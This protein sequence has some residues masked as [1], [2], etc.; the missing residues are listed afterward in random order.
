VLF[1]P[2]NESLVFRT[3]L[4]AKYRDGLKRT[5]S[6]TSV[7]NEGAFVWTQEYLRYRVNGCGHGVAVQDVMTEIDGHAAPAVCR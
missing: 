6:A 3:L 4:E 7:D 2:R 1:P 5:A